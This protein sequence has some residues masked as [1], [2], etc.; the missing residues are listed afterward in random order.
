[1]HFSGENLELFLEVPENPLFFFMEVPYSVK[2]G[3]F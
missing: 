1:M 3:K 2:L